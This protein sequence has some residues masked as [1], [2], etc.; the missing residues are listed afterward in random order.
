[1]TNTRNPGYKCRRC[2]DG[3]YVRKVRRKG[4]FTLVRYRQ[5]RTCHHREVTVEKLRVDNSKR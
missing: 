1:M 5:C 4:R 2:G 3:M